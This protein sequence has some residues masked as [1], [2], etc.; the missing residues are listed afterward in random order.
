MRDNYQ[1]ASYQRLKEARCLYNG[2]YYHSAIYLLSYAV[3]CIL[4]ARI[5]YLIKN[6][7]VK[8]PK[9]DSKAL[10]KHCLKNLRKLSK[11]KWSALENYFL[12]RDEKWIDMRYQ[13]DNYSEWTDEKKEEYYTSGCNIAQKTYRIIKKKGL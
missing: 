1:G 6:R 9:E 13:V 4:K 3:E 12:D 8:N 2:E 7:Q 5:R 11:I 10:K